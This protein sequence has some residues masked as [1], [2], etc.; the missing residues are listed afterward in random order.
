LAAQVD[1]TPP[2]SPS[3]AGTTP[4]VSENFGRA[5]DAIA[6]GCK[7]GDNSRGLR[8]EENTHATRGIQGALEGFREP[9]KLGA[10]AYGGPAIMV[11]WWPSSEGAAWCRDSYA[12]RPVGEALI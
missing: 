8:P 11:S 10:T 7:A 4:A 3:S 2:D 9:A 1:A 5:R 12:I 6:H